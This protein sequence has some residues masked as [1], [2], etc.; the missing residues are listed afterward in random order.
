MTLSQPDA[1]TY[2][3]VIRQWNESDQFVEHKDYIYQID[4]ARRP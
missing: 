2:H 3:I 4:D 1:H